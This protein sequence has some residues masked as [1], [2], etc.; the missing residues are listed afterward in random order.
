MTTR[1]EA[2]VIYL[3]QKVYHW[4][5]G[6][7][8]K[9][10]D[11]VNPEPWCETE[12]SAEPREGAEP[13]D[14]NEPERVVEP[15]PEDCDVWAL[16]TKRFITSA[17]G[18][19]AS[20]LADHSR[21]DQN[22]RRTSASG[23]LDQW[24]GAL[25]PRKRKKRARFSDFQENAEQPENTGP[26]AFAPNL[27]REPTGF[28]LDFPRGG[29][30]PDGNK[31]LLLWPIN[32]DQQPSPAPWFSAVC[33]LYRALH[34][35]LVWTGDWDSKAPTEPAPDSAVEDR[36]AYLEWQEILA[37]LGLAF[38]AYNLSRHD[39]TL[40]KHLRRIVKAER[41]CP[42]LPIVAQIRLAVGAVQARVEYILENLDDEDYE[43]L[44]TYED[45]I[46]EVWEMSTE[47]ETLVRLL[48]TLH[49]AIRQGITTAQR[50]LATVHTVKEMIASIQS[51]KAQ[52][53]SYAAS[54]KTGEGSVPEVD[55]GG[56]SVHPSVV[57]A[58]SVS[59]GLIEA[60]L[61]Q[62]IE[63]E[64]DRVERLGELLDTDEQISIAS[65]DVLVDSPGAEMNDEAMEDVNA[66]R[67]DEAIDE[68]VD[69]IMGEEVNEEAINEVLDEVMVDVN[70]Q[71][72]D[73]VTAEVVNKVMDKVAGKVKEKVT[74]KVRDKVTNMVVD[75]VIG[76]VIDKVSDE[77]E[78]G[79]D[80][81][82]GLENESDDQAENE[83]SDEE[84]QEAKE[85][86]NEEDSEENNEEDEGGSLEDRCTRWV[87]RVSEEILGICD[88][89]EGYG[90]ALLEANSA[91]GRMVEGVTTATEDAI[92]GER[93]A[94]GY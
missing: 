31:L 64:N 84:D 16:K 93:A 74:G 11:N 18:L 28:V 56:Y 13:D 35:T 45:V 61:Q 4:A 57:E 10:E 20:S 69:E 24:I 40:R 38:S 34:R 94:P 59:I 29:Y 21:D 50:I 82:S 48:A 72:I 65:L 75:Q 66:E 44:E 77:D 32:P 43:D 63:A 91:L 47:G 54:R 52:R 39:H 41:F 78:V 51:I 68:I 33:C 76:Q 7:N 87:A 12:E 27:N 9:P 23:K 1:L 26:S 22:R 30:G 60:A 14:I 70:E 81:E 8:P 88:I 80:D 58:A 53:D 5:D 36:Q 42:Y 6:K 89:Y 79:S 15:D 19:A 62:F 85:N 71:A 73:D 37:G 90:N 92:Q 86:D 67:M 3:H 55:E 83:E 49:K 17:S 46:S 2:A 25:S